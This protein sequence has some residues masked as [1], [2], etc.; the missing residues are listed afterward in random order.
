MRHPVMTEKYPAHPSMAAFTLQPQHAP[1]ARIG[2]QQPI[3]LG[4]RLGQKVH[5][6]LN[7]GSGNGVNMRQMPNHVADAG[8]WLHDQGSLGTWKFHA[9]DCRTARGDAEQ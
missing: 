3:R 6:T 8:Q 2:A 1:H 9:A 4:S 7:T 5:L